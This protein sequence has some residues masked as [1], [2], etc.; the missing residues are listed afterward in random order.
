MS[1]KKVIEVLKSGFFLVVCYSNRELE[2]VVKPDQGNIDSCLGTYEKIFDS[3]TGY[4]RRVSRKLQ[5]RKS[6]RK[7]VEF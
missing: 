5:F 2:K 7:V 4:I 6:D 1:R 3:R